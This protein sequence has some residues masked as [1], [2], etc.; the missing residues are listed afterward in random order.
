[1]TAIFIKAIT[2]LKRRRLQAAVIF[3]TTLLAVGTGTM[4]LT[5]LSQTHDPYQ[6]AFEA[7][8]GAHLQVA[9]DSRTDRQ[10]VAATAQLLGAT[11]SGGPYPATS[12]EFQAGS[13]KFAVDT[14][15]RD[16]PGG[17]VE[18]LR[19]TSGR[20]PSSNDEIAL[21]RSFSEL[22]N[23]PI[24]QKLK[25]VSVAE[26][27][28]LTVV[29]QVVDIDEGSADLS[30]QH[31][32]ML[33][34]AIPAVTGKN[35]AFYLMTYRFAT[36]PSSAQLQDDVDRLRAALPPGSVTGSINYILVRNIFNI[37]NQIV[38]SVLIAFSVFALAATAAIVANLVT[39]VVLAAYREIGI[40]KAIGFTPRQVVAVFELQILIP[41]AVACLVGIPT[42]TVASQ[43]LLANSSHA[44]GL[45]YTP[46]FSIGLDLVTLAGAL[47]VV[48]LAA[49]APAFRAGLLK[50][51]VVIAN[52]SAPR[53][54][55]GR[56]LR[57]LAANLRLPRPV[58]IGAGD[59]FARPARAILT[60]VAILIGLAT[61]TVALGLPRSF[62]AINNSETS[63]GNVDVVVRKSPALSDAE[64]LA[65]INAQ[66]E[67]AR[68]VAE[69]GENFTVPGVGDPV[70]ARIF[71]GDSTH[72]G[73]MLVAG[74]WFNGPGEVLA[75]K[76]LLQDG[77]LK[78]GD[79]FDATVHGSTVP[80]VVV[81]EI[82]DINN[83]GHSLFMDWGTL[84]PAEPDATPDGYLITL[85]P[86]SSVSAYVR[87]VAAAQ[88]DLLDVKP[89][90]TSIIAPVQIIDSVLLIL[91]AVIA[92]IGVGG[93]F[94]TLLLNTRERVRDTATLK[95]VGMS[96]RQVVAMVAASAGLIALVGGVVA[97]PVGVGLHRYLLDLISVSAGNDTP[98][99]AYGVFGPLELVAI[100]VIGVLIA[101]AAALIPGRLAARTNVVEV[102]HAE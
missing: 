78:I 98:P 54:Q 94:N 46:T 89:N 17:P 96:P 16:D 66:P 97:V 83:L 91:A 102:L 52:A 18:Q 47:L 8:Q 19:I 33:G 57:R 32:W 90:N 50:P 34:S 72:L 41:A 2:D 68:V 93:I 10:A 67:T 6:T 75:P 43:P 84:T 92:L 7:Q 38:T 85:A 86:G 13:R 101:V 81:G 63:A 73:Y 45:A 9:F 20:W 12:L 48:A 31:A 24:G 15:G 79:H 69:T 60:L 87:H 77:H 88:P 70:N 23:I 11:A 61:I 56:G 40:M 14:F 95:A 28:V 35:T 100:P 51:V 39:G 4:A 62:T 27:P 55:S 29:A 3:V 42:G 99:A 82:Y 74:R 71:R 26:E 80:L 22:N 5:L 30:S 49:L 65:V 58:V 25:V 76:A 36:D 53:G 64:A 1:M 21:T 44:L 59:A 37:T